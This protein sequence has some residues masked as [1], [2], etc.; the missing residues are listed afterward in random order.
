MPGRVP[1]AR[2]TLFEDRRRAVLAM[3]GIGAGLVMVLL[4]GGLLVGITRQETAYIDRSTAEVFV[5][6]EG[7]RTMQLSTTSLPPGTAELVS[8]VPGVAW[9]APLRQA[10]TIVSAGEARLIT[11]L[12]GYETSTGR[13]GPGALDEGREPRAG[14]VVVDATGAAQLGLAVGDSVDLAGRRLEVVG[15]ASGL[16]GMGNT[17]MFVSGEVFAELMGPGT[18]WL[19]A[20][21]AEGVDPVELAAR[22]DEVVPG[23]TAQTRSGFAAEQAG[24]VAD[25]YTDV[26]RTMTMIGFLIAMALVGLTLSTITAANLR[27]YGVVRSIGATPRDL[28]AVVVA[29]SLWAVAAATAL[30]TVLAYGL[31]AVL[32]VVLP[33]ISLVIQPGAVAVTAVGAVLVGLV[34]A[35]LPLRRVLR[36]EPATA[37][38]GAV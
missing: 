31:A 3:L 16:T 27:S 29:Q 34:A 11:Y 15:L 10:T 4:M 17:T 12:Y 26:I 25:L 7:V 19:L 36:V 6:Q 5:S 13:G 30:A 9:V 20:G 38:R 2:R 21:A 14:E 33:N 24:A 8:A 1:V 28:A 32:R 22:L 23:V 35:M 37:F 18:N